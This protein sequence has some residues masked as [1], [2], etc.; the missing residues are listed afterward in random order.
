M[1]QLSLKPIQIFTIFIL[2]L[3]A[4][5][6]APKQA[7]QEEKNTTVT[8]SDAEFQV[9]WEKVDL[10]W[11][12]RESNL[13]SS[14]YASNFTRI[15]PAGTSTSAEDL[16]NEMNAINGAYPDMTLELE[17]YDI[18]GNMVIVHWSVDGTFTGEL[19]GVNGNG[20]PFSNVVGVTV[21][22]VENGLII[23]DDSYWDTFAVFA[24]TGY[25]IASSE[26]E[27]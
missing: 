5:N 22:T 25:T 8:I 3:V 2:I 17:R 21:I 10:L 26:T 4:C 23:N 16:T 11:E 15:C 18:R 24:Q 27:S 19:G 6:P 14:V 9:L 13:I 1:K 12:K 20:K 7:E